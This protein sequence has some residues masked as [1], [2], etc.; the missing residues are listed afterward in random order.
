MGLYERDYGR[1]EEMTPWD[2]Y[3]RSQQP[4]SIVIILLV[5]TVAV[6]LLD[7]FT[8][9]QSEPP[10][11]MLAD[12]F[13]C[14]K[15]TIIQPWM[16]FQFLSYGFLHDQ[17]NIF[18]VAFNMLGLFVFGRMLE[19]RLGRFEFLRFYLVSIFARGCGWFSHLLGDRCA[20]AG[21]A[22]IGASGGDQCAHHFVRLPGSP[23]RI[24]ADGSLADQSVGLSGGLSGAE[25]FGVRDD[26]VGQWRAWARRHGVHGSHGRDSVRLFVFSPGLEPQLDGV[27]RGRFSLSALV[28]PDQ[29]EDSR[30]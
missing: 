2:Q 13:A 23:G 9:R 30:S 19:Q 21:S 16:W 17:Q 4:K 7:M 29:T 28:A 20:G 12:W 5:V 1:D 25:H 15:E 24:T 10:D 6:H 14:H 3:Q 26:V 27:R 18:H 8:V 22:V 11:S